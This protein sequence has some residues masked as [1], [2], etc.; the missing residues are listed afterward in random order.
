CGASSVAAVFVAASPKSRLKLVRTAVTPSRQ[1]C[2]LLKDRVVSRRSDLSDDLI[3]HRLDGGDRVAAG[4]VVLLHGS[5]PSLHELLSVGRC[6][7]RSSS[8]TA[9][10]VTLRLLLRRLLRRGLLS[11]ELVL[12]KL[13][14]RGLVRG[15]LAVHLR[16]V[17]EAS[18]LLSGR[19]GASGG[20][21]LRG[22][23]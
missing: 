19:C 18:L 2:S 3:L 15:H 6:R 23:H 14:L 11:R 4:L 13:D 10:A 22:A 17:S 1:R 5:D 20:G 21:I 12:S 8:R 9:R 7:S 16:V